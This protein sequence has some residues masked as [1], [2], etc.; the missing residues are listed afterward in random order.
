MTSDERRQQLHRLIDGHSETMAALR[1]ANHS[2]AEMNRANDVALEAF[3]RQSAAIQRMAD[4]N[5]R[6]IEASLAT[7][8]AALAL[9]DDAAGVQ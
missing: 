4:A 1:E 3:R 9:L 2:F 7:M 6:A 8:T 5:E